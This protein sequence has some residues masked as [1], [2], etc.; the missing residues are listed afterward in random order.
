MGRPIFWQA[1][2]TR[3]NLLNDYVEW[4]RAVGCRRSVGRC[5]IVRDVLARRQG[6]RRLAVGLFLL[7]DLKIG[8]LKP[9]EVA[10]WI[11]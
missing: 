11:P 2:P 3:Q 7:D 6:V 1:F 10:G 4:P 5:A 9:L 8:L